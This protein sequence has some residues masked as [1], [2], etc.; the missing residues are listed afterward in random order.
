M[1]MKHKTGL[2]IAMMSAMTTVSADYLQDSTSSVVR[3]SSGGCWHTPYTADDKAMAAC[4][5]EIPAKPVTVAK[6]VQPVPVVAYEITRLEKITLDDETY[7]GFDKASLKPAAQSKLDD[8]VVKLRDAED[9]NRV[10]ITGHT[11]QIGSSEYNEKLSQQRA[12]SVRNYLL[13]RIDSPDRVQTIAM[14]ES[15]PVVSCEGSTGNQLVSCLAPN[16][17][18]EI[19]VE[20]K[21]AKQLSSH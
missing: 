12:D 8:L 7:F 11:D 9:I 14:G 20:L 16:R 2:L 6:P 17:R 4:G 13:Q 3:N 15:Q 21:V 5:D 18:V 10:V 1:K 19:D